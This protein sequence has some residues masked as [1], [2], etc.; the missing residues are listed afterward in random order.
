MLSQITE[1][2]EPQRG[3][4]MTRELEVIISD[5]NQ[6]HADHL[7]DWFGYTGLIKREL[8]VYKRIKPYKEHIYNHFPE[9]IPTYEELNKVNQSYNKGMI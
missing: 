5:L 8:E 4:T 6:I 9:L 2:G 1:R 7:E 3:V